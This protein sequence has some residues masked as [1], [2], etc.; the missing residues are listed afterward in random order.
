MVKAV[1]KKVALKTV[2]VEDRRVA[3]EN[4][5]RRHDMEEGPAI[6][7]SHCRDLDRRAGPG[8]S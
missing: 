4:T 3:M 5:L 2:D 7:M 8:F 1:E 6:N